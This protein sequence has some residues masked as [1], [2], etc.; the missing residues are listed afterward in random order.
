LILQLWH[1]FG[2]DTAKEYDFYIENARSDGGRIPHL[3]CCHFNM[4]VP[5]SDLK[6]SNT[7]GLLSW[8]ETKHSDW[9]EI[10]PERGSIV[11]YT[12]YKNALRLRL[13]QFLDEPD[14]P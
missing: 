7:S 2:A 11:K 9:A 6:D 1:R 8:I 14:V 3:L 12:Q 4:P 5:P 10:S 13:I